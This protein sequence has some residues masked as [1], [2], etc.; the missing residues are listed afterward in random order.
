MMVSIII[1][2]NLVAEMLAETYY[3]WEIG[4]AIII[5]LIYI[6]IHVPTKVID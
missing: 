6:A 1:I 5:M 2:C 4:K 3:S